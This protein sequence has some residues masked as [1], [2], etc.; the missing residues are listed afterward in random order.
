[1]ETVEE[2]HNRR[3]NEINERINYLQSYI[4]NN[5]ALKHNEN[6][7][8]GSYLKR[9]NSRIAANHNQRVDEF[10]SEIE[11]LKMHINKLK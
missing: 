10:K 7:V 9:R 3:I 5:T 1:M 2:Y 8:G 11:G 4:D 6:A